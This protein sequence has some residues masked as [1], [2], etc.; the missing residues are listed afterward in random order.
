MDILQELHCSGTDSGSGS[1]TGSDN[2]L[3]KPADWK[4]SS[5][6]QTDSF[7]TLSRV[8]YSSELYLHAS[9]GTNKDQEKVKNGRTELE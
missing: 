6:C 9:C 1:G 7:M 4:G 3:E 5:T 2:S 8:F